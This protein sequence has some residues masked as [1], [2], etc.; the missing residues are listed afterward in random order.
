[1]RFVVGLVIHLDG[2]SVAVAFYALAID[3]VSQLGQAEH[4]RRFS[5]SK[6]L[7]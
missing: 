1:M 4:L 3:G 5:H 2:C 7:R 6:E